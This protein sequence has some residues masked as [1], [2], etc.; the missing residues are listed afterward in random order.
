MEITLLNLKIL[1]SSILLCK[2]TMEK[3]YIIYKNNLA[4]FAFIVHYLNDE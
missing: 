2:L 1:K 3:N 4:N